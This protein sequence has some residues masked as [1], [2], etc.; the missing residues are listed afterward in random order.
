[1]VDLSEEEVEW[2]IETTAKVCEAVGHQ[3]L[4][5]NDTSTSKG[6]LQ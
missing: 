4:A 1:M 2:N 3:M 6:P 5:V